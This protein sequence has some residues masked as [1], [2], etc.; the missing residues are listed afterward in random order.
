[1]NNMT[2]VGGLLGGFGNTPL[3]EL[4]TRCDKPEVRLFGKREGNNP[5]RS[6]N[7]QRGH[8]YLRSRRSILELIPVEDSG[9]QVT[10]WLAKME[11]KETDFKMEEQT[12]ASTWKSEPEFWDQCYAAQQTGWD[13]GG[14]H[15][16]LEHWLETGQLCPCQIAVPGCG[17][18]YEVVRL[19]ESQF[20]VTAI[21]FSAEPLQRLGEKLNATETGSLNTQLIQA[22]VL[23]FAHAIQFDA[24]YEQTCLCAIEVAQRPAYERQLFE[25]LREGGMLHIL[26]LQTDNASGQPPFHCN[27]DDMKQL[28]HE[29]RW[30]WCDAERE[31]LTRYDHPSGKVFE[32]ATRLKRKESQHAR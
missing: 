4:P 22:N 10:I 5:R 17:N 7:R 32:F 19:A 29:S 26:F 11:T 23:E 14:V 27:I 6:G 1:M 12:N 18:G 20:D 28:F 25:W 9:K 2:N 30:D 24:V 15:P 21:D 31:K 3:V 16:A 13:R 8:D